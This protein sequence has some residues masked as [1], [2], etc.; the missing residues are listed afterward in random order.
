MQVAHAWLV[1][2]GRA[3]E[4]DE[5]ELA[6]RFM[7]EQVSQLRALVEAGEIEKHAMTNLCQQLLSSNE[8]LY[9]E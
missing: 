4:R 6:C 5:F 2:Y 3:I 9:V 7:V 8:F 1:V